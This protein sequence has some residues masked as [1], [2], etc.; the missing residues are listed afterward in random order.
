MKCGELLSLVIKLNINEDV[1]KS[2]EDT[3]GPNVI[4]I[5]KEELLK[6]DFLKVIEERKKEKKERYISSFCLIW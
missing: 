2:I 1:I 3:L 4:P 5:L 6:E